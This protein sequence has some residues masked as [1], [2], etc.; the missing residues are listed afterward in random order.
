MGTTAEK[1]NHLKQ[2][3]EEIKTAIKNKG[4][5]VADTD[6]FRSYADKID[7]IVVSKTQA[8][9]LSVTEN[10]T[11][12][13]TPDTASGYNGLSNV[14]VT[15][16][17]SGGKLG[18]NFQYNY[19]NTSEYNNSQTYNIKIP[20]NK[21]YAIIVFVINAQGNTP[22]G[23]L[24]EVSKPSNITLTAIGSSNGHREHNSVQ[25]TTYCYLATK[26]SNIASEATIKF[27]NDWSN[28]GN[29]W[30]NGGCSYGVFYNVDN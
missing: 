4:V 2:T 28:T 10:K 14:T 12:T 9:A 13:V 7:D 6:T 19:Y 5:T 8:K 15:A 29:G 18:G 21:Q 30:G 23:T 17:V 26:T 20:A 27:K 16:N 24:E 1:L 22:A 3:K 11:Y 25:V